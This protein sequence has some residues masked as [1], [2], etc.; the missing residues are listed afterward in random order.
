MSGKITINRRG[1]K[2]GEKINRVVKVKAHKQ[3]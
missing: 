3:S 1:A 2:E